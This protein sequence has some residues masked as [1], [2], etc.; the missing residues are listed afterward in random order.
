MS[1]EWISSSGSNAGFWSY[2][3][4]EH[5]TCALPV[6]KSQSDYF[7]AAID[8]HNKYEPNQAL[9]AAGLDPTK[10]KSY[11]AGTVTSAFQ[12]AWNVKPVLSCNSAYVFFCFFCFFQKLL[13]INIYTS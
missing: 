1:C 4:N 3:W 7:N 11:S 12:K 13:Y 6:L 10:V 2:E 9:S 5:G 8:L